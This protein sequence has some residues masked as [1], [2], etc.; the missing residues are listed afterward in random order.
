MKMAPFATFADKPAVH[1]DILGEQTRCQTLYT[2]FR[3]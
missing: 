3:Y 1:S 2:D